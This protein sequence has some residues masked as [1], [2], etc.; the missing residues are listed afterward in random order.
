M[1]GDLLDRLSLRLPIFQAPM[2]GVST[3]ALAAA[4]SQAGGLGALG[5][6]ASTP[7]AA[8]EAIAA[9]R[10][11]TTAAFNANF[12]CHRPAPHNHE[13]ER[14]WIDRA[15]PLFE[16]F[17]ARPP[18]GLEEIY[19]SFRADD[20]MLALILE[21]RPPVVSFHFGLPTDDQLAALRN[22]GVVLIA[23]ATSLTEA[24]AI[25]RAG[26]DAV[27]AQGWEAGGHR[28]V[29][30]PG[31]PD[32]R[33]TTEALTRRLVRDVSLPV[34]A[35]G[36]LMT[37]SDI[38]NALEWGAAA[39][40]MG[41]A[42]I[43]CPESAADAAYRARLAQNRETVMTRVLSGRPARCLSGAFTHWGHGVE[44]HE[45][46]DYPRAYHLAKALNS[47]ARTYGETGYAAHWAG[48]G[49]A[50]AREMPAAQLMSHLAHELSAA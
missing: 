12:F 19:T 38:K 40:Q 34:I 21:M 32:E 14:Q 49:T 36:G 47:A 30:D 1:P 16:G 22:A 6:G 50:K 17:G 43:A 27:I 4:V 2:A 20:T 31:G 15:R 9:T 46:P 29:F 35:A 41:T 44:A 48:E 33:L 13:V 25:E 39:A 7:E 8:A 18:D 3:P 37:G 45:V 5:L 11:L 28:G 10:A 26:L 24:H 42:F 23:T